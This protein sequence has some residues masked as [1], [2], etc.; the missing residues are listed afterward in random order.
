MKMF[1]E[2]E[3]LLERFHVED[4]VTVSVD[5]EP[6]LGENDSPITPINAY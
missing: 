5:P 3:L 4:V 2:P 1:V 6:E